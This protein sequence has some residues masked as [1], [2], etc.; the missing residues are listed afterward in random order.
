MFTWVS[1]A[2]GIV[3]LFNGFIGLFRDQQLRQE[4][5]QAQQLKEAK[6]ELTTEQKM[7][8]AGVNVT[9]QSARDSL[10]HGDY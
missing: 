10:L 3:K 9:N 2:S 4:G 1:L 6:D 7:A 8:Q 5:A